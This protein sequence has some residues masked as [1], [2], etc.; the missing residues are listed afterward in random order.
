MLGNTQCSETHNM[1]KLKTMRKLTK[2]LGCKRDSFLRQTK[3]NVTRPNALQA[4]KGEMPLCPIKLCRSLNGATEIGLAGL[5]Q[6][7]QRARLPKKLETPVSISSSS[8]CSASGSAANWCCC[9]Q[10]ARH[11]FFE[12]R[13]SKA[14]AG[15]PLFLLFSG[16]LLDI[17]QSFSFRLFQPA[18]CR[19]HRFLLP[20][21]SQ[22]SIFTIKEPG[23][24]PE[25]LQVLGGP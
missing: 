15:F 18:G 16:R 11:F 23:K 12:G 20:G 7:L 24:I 13:R 2:R 4:T 17:L 21:G 19:T 25:L 9:G 3:F 8:F 5:H 6:R 1:W 22:L 14:T 10:L